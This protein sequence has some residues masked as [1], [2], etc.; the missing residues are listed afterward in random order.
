MEG[1][2]QHLWVLLQPRFLAAP[3]LLLIQLLRVQVGLRF[4][5]VA[6]L[7]IAIW[8]L[9]ARRVESLALADWP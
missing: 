8:M 7:A 9:E 1:R 4:L 6:V 5:S 3:V 2:A